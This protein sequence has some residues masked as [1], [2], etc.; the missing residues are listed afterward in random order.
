MKTDNT[1]ELKG[2]QAYSY[3]MKRFNMSP[4]EAADTMKKHNQYTDD[5][6]KVHTMLNKHVLRQVK[7][8]VKKSGLVIK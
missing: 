7:K 4:D 3:I 6:C 5:V 8:V 1:L 2:V